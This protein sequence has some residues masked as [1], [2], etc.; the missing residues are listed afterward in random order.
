MPV[1][2]TI[3]QIPADASHSE[4][5]CLWSK[6]VRAYT[7][8]LSETPTLERADQGVVFE[9]LGYAYYRSAFQSRKTQSFFRLLQK[10]VESYDRAVAC[11]RVAEK[12]REGWFLR[13]QAMK[14]YAASWI[15]SNWLTKKT[16]LDEAW[17]YG[18]R[19]LGSFDSLANGVEFGRTYTQLSPCVALASQYNWSF[20]S[21]ARKL[22]QAIQIGRQA[23]RML[24]VS[25]PKEELA[26][27]LVKTALFLDAFADH[28]M[29]IR[30]QK[31]ADR[32]ALEYWKRASQI[33]KEDALLELS[34]LPSGFYRIMDD[35]EALS[36]CESALTIARRTRDNMRIGFL[37]EQMAARTFWKGQLEDDPPAWKKLSSRTLAFAETAASLFRIVRF[38]SPNDGVIW[39]HS[40]YAEYFLDQSW[41]EPDRAKKRALVEKSL[42]SSPE[43]LR[44][45]RLSRYPEILAYAHRITSRACQDLADTE[46][47]T[48]RRRNLLR[49]ALSHRLKAA[50][51]T[52]RVGPK[53]HW[54]MGGTL[55]NVGDIQAALAEFEE[56][57]REKRRLVLAAVRSKAK[58]LA[59]SALFVQSLAQVQSHVLRAPLARYYYE[60]GDLLMRLYEL[61]RNERDLRKAVSSYVSA[62]QWFV[63]TPRLERLAL[64]HWKAG[65]TYDRLGA[66]TLAAENFQLSSKAYSTVSRKIPQ[67]GE[68]FQEYSKYLKAWN[69]IE[70]ARHSHQKMQ[71]DSAHELYDEA[72]KLHAST[73]K[74]SFL[75]VYYSAWAKLELAESLAKNGSGEAAAGEFREAAELFEKSRI[76]FHNK[77]ASLDQPDEKS[78][79]A[80]L[81][82]GK[83]DEYC[84]AR[85]I[86]EEANI[87]ERVGDHR[88]SSEKFGLAAGMLREVA[89]S[90]ESEK[91]RREVSLLSILCKA[92]QVSSEL[93]VKGSPNAQEQASNLFAKAEK[94]A[95]D[96]DAVN[97]VAGHRLFCMA[98]IASRRLAETRDRRFYE[99]AMENFE[100]ASDRYSSA[101][102]KIAS[103]HALARRLLLEASAR[104]AEGATAEHS[105]KTA[106][107]RLAIALL[108]RS[109]DSFNR[110]RQWAK[111]EE[112]LRLLE[113]VKEKQDLA[114]DLSE[115]FDAA[116]GGPVNIAF[117]TPA[118]GI[119]GPV[120][121]DRFEHADIDV[122]VVRI[123]TDSSFDDRVELEIRVTNI[124]KNAIRLVRIDDAAPE[125]ARLV[126]APITCTI[127]GRSLRMGHR[128]VGPLKTEIVR[129]GLRMASPGIMTLRPKFVFNDDGGAQKERILEPRTLVVSRIME[130]LSREFER[131]YTTK[132]LPQD[133][134]GWRTLMEIVHALRIPR[135]NVYGEARYGQL[136]G[137][138]LE[139]L[140]KSS[141]VEFRRFP[142]ER[143]RG[144][145]VT[146]VRIFQAENKA[147]EHVNQLPT[148]LVQPKHP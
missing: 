3:E 110:A 120:G 99:E 27:A 13:C 85:M 24:S 117:P 45:A 140:V 61:T 119:E 75:T 1:R 37:S 71:F 89:D 11:F 43:L 12:G 67:L 79:V 113:K 57:P 29:E 100:L 41:N 121:L 145:E 106:L 81:F 87:A 124:G 137:R 112:V 94:M 77:L 143:G 30:K 14:K 148:L 36:I 139:P 23:V 111:K 141:L 109:A 93:E 70:R 144:G 26:K 15:S 88:T 8:F 72:R 101:G 38:T 74:W 44:L 86:L 114:N 62:A 135:S 123:P 4:E 128:K 17:G 63:N 104:I 127:H 6:A 126:S 122:D 142:G 95:H 56:D 58:A 9:R 138:K 22:G 96:E 97:L 64:S 51:I 42:R 2:Q 35:P 105:R 84:H 48:R 66:Y 32:E 49:R 54:N 60:Y 130:F 19:A 146:K 18:I 33:A 55:R 46:T 133:R 39:V 78:M 16:L 80:R 73:S 76:S 40:P 21:R 115:I 91:D 5:K 118:H 129:F 103:E 59:V 134:C 131:D 28:V 25:G 20:R 108:G 107:L 147:R 52:G 50:E 47:S 7:N 132:R 83:W 82:E 90:M 92:W 102:F 116:S 53:L 98:L 10:A 65:Q 69:R 31:D 125:N 136:F 68:L 34:E